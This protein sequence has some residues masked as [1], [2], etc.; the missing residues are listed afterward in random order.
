[1]KQSK[2][3]IIVPIVLMSAALVGVLLGVLHVGGMELANGKIYHKMI[4]PIFRLLC[5]LA[6][7]V[8]A[9]QILEALGWISAIARLAG[10]VTRWGHLTQESGA[11][12]IS[13]FVSGL[14]AN[15]MLMNFYTEEKISRRE[16]IITYLVTS[17][18]PTFM[19]HLPSTLFVV[20]SLAGTAGLLYVAITFLAACLRTVGLLVYSRRVLRAPDV[21]GPSPRAPAP[22]SRRVASTIWSQFRS[23]FT[24]V[25]LYT[26]PIY[27]MIFLLNEF[28]MFQ[29]LRQASSGWLSQ[30]FLPLEAAGVVVFALAAEFTSGMAAAGALLDSGSLTVKQTTLALIVGTII[31]APIRAI[32]HQLPSQVGLFNLVLGTELLLMSHAL[33][34]LSLLAVVIPF[35]LLA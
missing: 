15:T 17:A 35:A 25:V 10:P 7:G 5:Y 16:L 21:A 28:G 6:V 29:W 2:R 8:L 23:R 19:L 31:A 1:M 32:R 18:V 30:E 3:W 13:G 26:V 33:R 11:A 22:G 20:A 27:I 14:V 34:I 12:M 4:V 9:G 24:R